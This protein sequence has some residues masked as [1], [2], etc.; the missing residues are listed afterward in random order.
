MSDAVF[1]GPLDAWIGQVLA[2]LS[3]GQRGRLTRRLATELR[4]SQSARIAA[5]QNPDGSGFEPRKPQPRLRK[6]QG[7]IR[8][9][10]LF[11]QMRTARYL[12]AL[13]TP[14]EATVAIAG[15][16][17]RIARVHQYGLVDAVN[18]RGLQVRYPIRQILGFT[19]AD[20]ALIASTVLEHLTP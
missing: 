17:A 15:S 13:S 3:S 5:Q 6:K 4:R 2:S 7:R 10:A 12:K 16:A 8:R 11:Q 19:E 14:D 9:G 20:R 1:T 18:R